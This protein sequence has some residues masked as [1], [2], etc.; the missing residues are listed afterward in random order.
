MTDAYNKARLEHP[1]YFSKQ[2]QGPSKPAKKERTQQDKDR[3]EDELQ[4]ALKLSLQEFEQQKTGKKEPDV[5]KPLPEIQPE[6]E[7]PPVETVATVSKVRA[8]YDLVSYE[9]DELSFRKGDVITVIESVYRDWWRGSL[10]SGKIGIFPLNYV[11]PIVN[12]SPQDIAKEIEIENKLITEEQ[13]KIERLLAILSSQQIET[14][15]EDEVTHL[16]N[17][18]IPLRIQLGNSIDKYGARQ[19]ELKVLNQLLN[20]EIK[21]YNEL[22]DKL[23]SSRAK[24]NTG[25]AMYQMSPYPTEQFPAN[26]NLNYHNNIINH[27]HSLNRLAIMHNNHKQCHLNSPSL[28]RHNHS[29]TNRIQGQAHTKK[30][31]NIWDTIATISHHQPQLFTSTHQVNCNNKIQVQDLGMMYIIEL[32]LDNPTD[33]IH[34][35]LI[36][37][38]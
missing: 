3:E 12:K 5:N 6:P 17:E 29:I 20:S 31:H 23:I 24:H 8:L 37:F 10:P 9:P 35:S 7:S 15:N 28:N 21:L 4:R 27:T 30:F 33:I 34:V 13:R 22:L 19:E 26:C 32:Y 18:I 2:T 11:T 16:Y 36:F 38:Y 25:G 1:R 14:I